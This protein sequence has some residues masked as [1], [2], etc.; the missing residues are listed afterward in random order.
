[1]NI[2]YICTVHGHGKGGHFRSL[3][4][5]AEAAGT[6]HSVLVLSV[7]VQPSGVLE[8]GD[9]EYVHIKYDFYSV[10]KMY[11]QVKRLAISHS[12]QCLHF[13]DATSYRIFS[14][15]PMLNVLKVVLNKCGGPNIKSF[16]AASSLVVFSRENESY[17]RSHQRFKNSQVFLISNRVVRAGVEPSGNDLFPTRGG[18]KVIRICRI[19]ETYEKS[20][21]DS[22]NLIKFLV[23]KKQI[24]CSLAIVGVIESEALY[25][26]LV[27]LPLVRAGYVRIFTSD[28]Y[29]DNAARFLPNADAV[30][31]TGRGMMEAMEC[32]LPCFAIDSTG[33][34]PVV[35]DASTFETAYAFNFS[36]RIPF[37]LAQK[38]E[39]LSK[40][41]AVAKDSSVRS[42]LGNFC[43]Q[44]FESLFEVRAGMTEYQKVY[45]F[46]KPEGDL[47][48]VK[49]MR[50]LWGLMSMRR[51]ARN[52]S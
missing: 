9:F 2:L 39:S 43:L 15:F 45:E 22:I 26:R 5:I 36:Q 44:K 50:F 18:L 19:G 47:S 24:E 11:D 30:V 10:S 1:M 12:I 52:F 27:S 13:F 34:L 48:A 4:A 25:Q 7:G 28:K 35:I 32:G 20:I 46:A 40:I 21:L 41:D 16:P 51:S 42:S 37:S 14:L 38:K 23:T 29:T 6:R 31:G 17:Y 33:D 49:L 8:V 3:R